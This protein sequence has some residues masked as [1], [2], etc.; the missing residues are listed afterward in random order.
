MAT[1]GNTALT[2]TD[3]ATRRDPSSG[4]VDSAIVELLAESNEILRDMLWIEGN[5]VTG[6]RTTMRTGLPDVIW[7]K[8]NAGIPPSKSTSV[9]VDEAVGSLEGVSVLD[10]AVAKLNGSTAAFRLSEN[11]SFLESMNQEMAQTI[12]FGDHT[13]NP[14]EFLGLSPR[15]EDLG[16][17]NGQNILDAGGTGSDNTSVWL[18]AWGF[19]SVC[20]IFPKGSSMGLTHKDTGE[21][22]ATDSD[23][24]EFLAYKDHYQWEAGI[25]L[26]DWRYVVRIANIDVS[27]LIADSSA[28]DLTEFMSR[29]IDRI[30]NF[31][32][33]KPV[34]YCTRTVMSFLKIQAMNKSLGVALIDA[35]LEQHGKAMAP[36][37][38]VFGIPVRKVDQL[39]ENEARIV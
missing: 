15:Y 14:E 16:A 20:G 1:I 30:P 10:L 38:T 37:L 4:G 36:E 25:A 29:A 19:K 3:F 8:L 32:N 12:F 9:Q 34:F 39:I 31:A 24:N 13:I 11:V 26:K 6:H 27:N 5:L 21:Q 35:A 7:R 23:G 17:V 33:V 28:A 18:I 22:W 2:L